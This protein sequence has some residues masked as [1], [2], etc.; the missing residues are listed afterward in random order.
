MKMALCTFIY[1][2][3]PLCTLIDQGDAGRNQGA[4]QGPYQGG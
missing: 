4:D 2:Y 3:L 1:L